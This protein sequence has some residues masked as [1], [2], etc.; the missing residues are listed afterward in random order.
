MKKIYEAPS[1]EFEVIETEEVMN[2]SFEEGGDVGLG[3]IIGGD[4]ELDL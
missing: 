3:S 2:A 4:I 1:L